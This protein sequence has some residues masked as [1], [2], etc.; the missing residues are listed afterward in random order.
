[1]YAA[2]MATI[3]CKRSTTPETPRELEGCQTYPRSRTHHV[4]EVADAFCSPKRRAQ[5]LRC[6][7]VRVR[8]IVTPPKCPSFATAL[9][10]VCLPPVSERCPE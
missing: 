9:T 4:C 3:A 1:M 2:S 6:V 7:L 10:R 5:N 8:R